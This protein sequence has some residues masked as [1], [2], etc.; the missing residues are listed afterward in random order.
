[1]ASSERSP[2]TSQHHDPCCRTIHLL[3]KMRPD[4]NRLLKSY[5]EKQTLDKNFNFD[6]VDGV[7]TADTEH[8]SEISEAERLGDNLK[9]YWAF[10]ILLTE[11]LEEQR[12][13]LTPGDAAFHESINSVVAQV[14][15]L[16]YQLEQLMLTMK[17]SL[18]AREVKNT[19]NTGE[20]GLFE[21]KVRGMK[22]LLELDRWIVRSIRD[23]KKVSRSIEEG[24]IPRVSH[25][26]A[27]AQKN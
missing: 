23:L 14:T 12:S 24:A 18:P 11:I 20:K 6:S 5:V 15:A 7:P 8:W 10:Q 13:T 25:C 3:R 1:M 22:V 26:L 16:A 9:A 17:H 27:Q 4:I 19:R 21:K 2:V